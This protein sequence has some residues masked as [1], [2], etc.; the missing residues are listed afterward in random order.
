MSTSTL[1]TPLDAGAVRADFPILA[2]TNE[3]GQPLT[4]LDSAASS[5]KPAAVLDA[6]DSYYRSYNANI[7]RGVYAL[8]E[9]ATARYEEARHLVADFIGAASPRECVFVRNTTEAINLVA[10]TWGR[11]HVGPGDLIVLTVMDHHSNLVPW[12]ML[13]EEKGADLAHVRITSDGRLEMDHLDELLRREPKLVAF[14]HVSNAL[15]TVN[16]AAE[17]VRRAHAAG[18]L[19]LI[20]GAQSVPHLPVDVRVLDCDFLA[21]S[22]HKMLAPMGSGVLYGKRALLE[23]MPPFMGGG[24]MIRKV[25]LGRSTWADVPAKFEAGT[26]AVG[27]AIGLGAAVEYLSALGMDRVRDHERELTA[28]ALDRLAEVPDLT[29]YGP[30]DPN[31][32]SGAVSFT[33]GDVHPHDVAA[34]LDGE[35]VAV[36]AGHHCCQPLMRELGLLATTRASFYVYNTE[37]DVDR[38]AAAL[39]KATA[40]FA[41]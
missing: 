22:G 8:S 30:A 19:V 5:Q 14:P 13:A 29:V 21:F 15:G 41:V 26:P 33:V 27:E 18:S 9:K 39:R 11:R 36:R 25:E 2:E 7:H 34:I 40:I 28:Y 10:Q 31:Q 20:D 1:V 6:L 24:S 4:F 3:R 32:R 17:I 37:E 38:L 23:A 35:N 16:D 12:Q